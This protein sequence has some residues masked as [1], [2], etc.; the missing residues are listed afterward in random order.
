MPQ[1]SR[2]REPGRVPLLMI[3]H[4]CK[5][6]R[7]LL[8]TAPRRRISVIHNQRRNHW[9]RESARL[10]NPGD[11]RTPVKSSS[12]LFGREVELEEVRQQLASTAHGRP[13]H[14]ALIGPRA[15][16]NTSPLNA[17]ELEARQA[18]LV[19]AR[20][21]LDEE[22][23]DDPYLFFKSLLEGVVL[24][25]VQQSLLSEED[26]KFAA[27]LRQVHM[28]DA[29][30]KPSEQLLLFGM[31]CGGHSCWRARRCHGPDAQGGL[32]DAIADCA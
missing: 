8:Q 25:L 13:V 24:S 9:V 6:T 29:S 14:V 4:P 19:T 1:H 26:P 10:I 5:G 12:R 3:E 21:D 16:G 17:I 28:A 11:F 32:R 27:W 15:A 7:S 18:N 30:V 20:I 2:C 22:T 23:V 31:G